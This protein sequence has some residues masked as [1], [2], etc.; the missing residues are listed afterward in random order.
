M[1]LVLSG[2]CKRA[3][4]YLE[5]GDKLLA[6]GQADGAI[7]NY[8]KAIQ[9]DQALGDAYYKLGVA[10]L[11]KENRPAALAAL[12]TARALLPNRED[13]AVKYAD[14]ELEM[15][16]APPGRPSRLYDDLVT[17]SDKLLARNP[18]SYDGLR[19]KGRLALL[20]ARTDTAVNF[21]GRANAV[22]PLQPDVIMLWSQ[23][24]LQDSRAP[25]G[26]R[27]ALRLIET[28]KTYGP[29]YDVLIRHYLSR[30]RVS[31]AENLLKSKADNNPRQIE[32]I[33]QL[34]AWYSANKKKD[35]ASALSCG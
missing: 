16:L 23:I 13:I 35:A 2:A 25:E 27:L 5:K 19:L 21:F 3:S 12:A 8:R 28:Q 7:L 26:E 34:A 32:Y 10:Q 31:E 29:M 1:V 6:A 9:K 20:D 22:K 17:T 11:Q 4:D 33:L 30:N 14:L 18:N 24:L 15:L